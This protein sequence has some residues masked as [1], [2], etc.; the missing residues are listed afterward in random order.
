MGTKKRLKGYLR[1]RQLDSGAARVYYACWRDERGIKHGA[2][3]GAAHVRDSGRKTPR[4]AIIWR[5]G[6][7]P[8]PTPEH[9][10]PREAQELLRDTLEAVEEGSRQEEAARRAVPLH[11]AAG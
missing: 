6:D 2:R 5:A 3:L 10:T 11:R 8:K 4:G 7:G 9:L 1:V